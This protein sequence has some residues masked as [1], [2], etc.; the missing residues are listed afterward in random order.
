MYPEYSRYSEYVTNDP[1]Y[2]DTKLLD[3]GYDISKISIK[4]DH[5][6][7]IICYKDSHSCLGKVKIGYFRIDDLKYGDG[8]AKPIIRIDDYHYYITDES[9]NAIKIDF[10]QQLVYK[11]FIDLDIQLEKPSDWENGINWT[12][13][14][15]SGFD[16]VSWKQTIRNTVYAFEGCHVEELDSS[17]YESFIR[18]DFEGIDSILELFAENSYEVSEEA[19]NTITA[20][21]KNIKSIEVLNNLAVEGSENFYYLIEIIYE[22][23]K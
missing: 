17:Y 12:I 22:Y 2:L 3:E 4:T 8:A 23:M 21:Y 7:R 11:S 15:N 16:F 20:N 18:V 9:I 14:E 5:I 1:L 6:D 10:E 13:Y 19:L